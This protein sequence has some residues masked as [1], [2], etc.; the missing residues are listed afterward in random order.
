L[1]F[2]AEGGETYRE[3]QKQ[4]PQQPR[5]ARQK[6]RQQQE[7]PQQQPQSTRQMRALLD[8]LNPND[9]VLVI[10]DTSQHQG[11]ARRCLYKTCRLDCAW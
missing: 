8:K 6:Q 11:V 4:K 7:Q 10:G 5:R 1:N 3:E 2:S 9:R